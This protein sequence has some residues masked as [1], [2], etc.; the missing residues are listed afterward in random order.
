LLTSATFKILVSIPRLF[1]K[2]NERVATVEALGAL[3]VFLA[4]A[5]AASITGIALPVDGGWTAH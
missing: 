3:T 2:P 1:Q 5:A 4:S